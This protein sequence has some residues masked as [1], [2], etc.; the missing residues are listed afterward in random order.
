[1]WLLRDLL[2]WDA[3]GPMAITLPWSGPKGE[4]ATA[5]LAESA[6]DPRSRETAGVRFLLKPYH[7]NQLTALIKAA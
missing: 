3:N 5:G 2:R 4:R 7:A 6:R 1:M